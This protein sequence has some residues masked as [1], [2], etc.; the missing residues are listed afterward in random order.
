MTP[1]S[2]SLG[3]PRTGTASFCNALALILKG[4]VYHS[5]TQLLVSGDEYHIKLQ[6]EILARTPIRS[7]EDKQFVL[8][9][10][11]TLTDGYVA[12]ADSSL[13]QFVPELLELYPD[14]V[15]ICTVRDPEAWARSMGELASASLQNLLA[16]VLFWVPCLRYFPRWVKVLQA[17]RWG[18]LYTRPGEQPSYGQ[19]TWERHIEYLQRS[20]PKD[21][22]IFY[23]VKDGWDPLCKVL[24]VPVPKDVAFPRMNDSDAMDKFAKKQ[25]ASGLLRWTMVV[26]VGATVIG[27]GWRFWGMPAH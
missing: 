11:K 17:G 9:G 14:A 18:E 3:L 20:V 25:M 21:R 10:L 7:P 8:D 6:I 23:N 4:P 15:V 13:C 5:G 24:D 16:L 19:R 27:T 22:L 2:S 1:D 26:M 12:T